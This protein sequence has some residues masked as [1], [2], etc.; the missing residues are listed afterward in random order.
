MLAKHQKL[1]TSWDK[2]LNDGLP[3]EL[4]KRIIAKARNA[5]NVARERQRKKTPQQRDPHKEAWAGIV[6]VVPTES[7]ALVNAM[8]LFEHVRVATAILRKE[9]YVVEADNYLEG[10]GE[11]QVYI[12][13]IRFID[14]GKRST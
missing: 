7:A 10:E 9:G 1:C 3:E 12:A 13:G 11:D 2:V 4:R 14:L 5:A 8:K 6:C